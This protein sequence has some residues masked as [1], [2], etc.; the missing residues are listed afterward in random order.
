MQDYSKILLEAYEKFLLPLGGKKVPTPY[1]IN[2][3]FQSDR[4]KYGKSDSETL[5]EDTKEFAKNQNFDLNKASV[6]EIRDFMEKNQLGIDC[7][8]FVYHVL[9]YLLKQLGKGNLM[10]H[11]F[12]KVSSTNVKI[13]TDEKFTIP[14][15]GFENIQAGDLIRINSQDAN[16]I[17]IVLK[18]EDDKI[19]YAHSSGLTKTTGVHTDQIV[20]GKFPAELSVFS[21][22]V[23]AGDGIRRLKILS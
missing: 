12:P 3:P 16:H 4:Q 21:Y 11:G 6:E 5:L 15:D 19:L 17:L 8:G 9:D 1:R 20:N 22:N 18:A 23:S 7:S 14:V 13:L 2:I 10:V